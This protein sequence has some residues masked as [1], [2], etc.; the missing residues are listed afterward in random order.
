MI[1]V[2]PNGYSYRKTITIDHT[3]VSGSADLTNL[4]FLY[5]VTDADM[6]SLTNGGHVQS[7]LGWDIRFELSDGTK[8]SHEL[9][10]YVNTTG[11]MVVWIKIPTVSY[12]TDSIIYVYYGKT[13]LSATEA[14][15]AG[16]WTSSWRLVAHFND[17]PNDVSTYAKN[18][19][20]VNSPPYVAG[21][22]R[23]ALSLDGVNQ[24]AIMNGTNPVNPSANGITLSAWV[25]IPTGAGNGRRIINKAYGSTNGGRSGTLF[26]T[27]NN[28]L[29]MI[30]VKNDAPTNTTINATATTVIPRDTWVYVSGTYNIATGDINVYMNG[31]QVGTTANNPAL[32]TAFG[33]AKFQVGTEI[34]TG[35]PLYLNC[36]IEEVRVRDLPT[37]AGTLVTEYNN[38]NSPSTFF[39]VGTEDVQM[40]RV[41][42]AITATTLAKNKTFT[43][44]VFDKAGTTLIATWSPLTGY[45]YTKVINGGC[46]EMRIDLPRKFDEYNDD[47][48]VSFLN[49]VEVWIQDRDTV[50]TSGVL[51]YA[52]FIADIEVGIQDGN[53]K[54]TI[55]VFGHY[56]RLAYVMHW[57]SVNSKVKMTYNSTDPAN[58]V[59]DVIDKFIA[60]ESNPFISY[61]GASIPLA[62][63]TVSYTSDTKFGLEVLDRIRQMTGVDYYYFF[64][65]Y[66]VLTFRQKPSTPTHSFTMQKNVQNLTIKKSWTDIANVLFA[67]NGL[68]E[69]DPNF[70]SKRYYNA[71]SIAAYWSKHERLSDARITD[72]TTML[73]LGTAFVGANK[74]P[75]ISIQFRVTDN[76]FDPDK[77]YDIESINP[78]D[79]CK[80]QNLSD[81][82]I[83]SSN[84]LIT[85]VSV[86]TEGKYADIVVEDK[87]ALTGKELND[88]RRGLD[89]SVYSDGITN[90]TGVA[91]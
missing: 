64:D 37:S 5:K 9:M 52:G 24:Y 30:I 73:K 34:D 48:S 19:T 86:D 15:I 63:F 10:Y 32:D 23:K 20:L 16:V 89:Q 53:E 29:Q 69:N 68:Q 35:A 67:W 70:L 28:F 7:D 46:G 36:L 91:V 25:Y 3:K 21:K 1:F 60:N 75:N 88:I 12:T 76:N 11:E 4:R 62:G 22:I 55:M 74:D 31:V 27:G 14:D 80:I 50:G 54:T 39:S 33:T 56:T 59:K 58:I 87:R 18:L 8:L 6:R 71:V 38:Q 85:S 42:G 47:L 13:G 26:F 78:G 43:V 44:K 79:T 72:A 49:K 57:D 17:T 41:N 65:A 51:M 83:Y 81:P 84:L 45:P 66:G 90:V 40:P 61:T 82:D 77:G 2:S